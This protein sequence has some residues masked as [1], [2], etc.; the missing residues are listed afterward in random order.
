MLDR[1][2]TLG[3][4]HSVGVDAIES[5]LGPAELL[6]SHDVL[7]RPSRVAAVPGL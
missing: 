3:L 6:D 5:L 7:G 2:E 1:G 4:G